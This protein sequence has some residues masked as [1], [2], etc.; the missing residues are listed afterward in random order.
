MRVQDPDT[1]SI[2]G[3]D[4]VSRWRDRGDVQRGADYDERWSAMAEAGQSIHGEADLVWSL[5]DAH[6]GLAVLDAGCGTGRIAIE[7][8]RRGLH[9]V[10]VDLDALML[11]QAMAKA[12]QLAWEQG[13]LADVD[14]EREFDLVVMA[15][16]VMIFLAPHTEAAVIANM[17]R[18]IVAG[19]VLVAGF[20]L[21]DGR[22][23]VADYDAHA[24]EAGLKFVD[25]WST[26]D[27]RPFSGDDYAVSVHRRA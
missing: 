15:G 22:I 2:G 26:W 1:G 11:E 20:Q 25:R 3:G 16:N 8:Q 19:G 13:D 10:G 6:E 4:T 14:L 18:H 24:A 7:L 27:R 9:V 12:P 5:L 17:A 21:G 23:T